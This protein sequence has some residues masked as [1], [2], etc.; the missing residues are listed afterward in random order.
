M[1][2]III[3]LIASSIQVA[4]YFKSY[5]NTKKFAELNLAKQKRKNNL[6]D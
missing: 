2:I 5:N 6:H 4:L 3:G 1:L